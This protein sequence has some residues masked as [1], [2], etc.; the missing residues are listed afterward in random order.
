MTLDEDQTRA[1]WPDPNKGGWD[2]M[3]DED[4]F[5]PPD[6]DDEQD[7]LTPAPPTIVRASRGASHHP[8]AQAWDSSPGTGSRVASLQQIGRQLSPI[9]VPLPFAI[10][11]FLFT[12]PADAR[13]VSYL[14]ALPLGI[15]LLALVVIQG[16][17]LYY[18]GSNDTL[19][20][21][22]TIGGYALFLLVGAYALF[23]FGGTLLL[24][25]IFLVIGGIFGGRAIHQVPEGYADIVL[26]FGKYN[27][28][29]LPGLNL[30]FPWEKVHSRMRTK[31]IT[32]TS[33]PVQVN[34]SRDQDVKLIASITYQLLPEDAHIAALNIDNWEESLRQH[35][36]GTIQSVVNDLSPSDVVA[37]AHHVHSS[38]VEELANPM[39]ETRWDRLN[40][41][42]RIR[43]QD[44]MATRGIHVSLVHVQDITVI[45]HLAPASQPAAQLAQQAQHIQQMAPLAAARPVDVG[46]T[47][48]AAP[49]GPNDMY[50]LQASPTQQVPPVAPPPPAAQPHPAQPAQPAQAGQADHAYLPVVPVP[51]PAMYETLIE[52]YN[53]I[54]EG[55][56]TD[57]AVV[58]DTAARFQAIANNPEASSQ[59]HFD[60]ARAAQNLLQRAN[61]MHTTPAAPASESK[62][63]PAPEPRRASVPPTPGERAA[64]HPPNDN[65]TIGG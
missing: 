65:L 19:W 59:F 40:N 51:N 55:R 57:R 15:I 7:G 12:L 62:P 2:D 13:G 4:E 43:M 36:L 54:R 39:I 18:A 27:R 58:L 30:L 32:W 17:F 37:W 34:I 21:L 16:T 53:S 28:T 52:M 5:F 29:L 45:P 31:E 49:G 42:L 64:R 48:G 35:F 23:G 14:P 3:D 1:I 11:I 41:A 46:M 9:L 38:T 56:I 33:P 50:A 60:A 24:L 25:V 20:M 26:M 61:A 47:R 22:S 6:D 44:Q 10:L 63:R 8:Q